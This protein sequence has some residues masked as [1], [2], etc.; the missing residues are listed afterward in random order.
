MNPRQALFTIVILSLA[1]C[2]EL[3]PGPLARVEFA[4]Y[5]VSQRNSNHEITSIIFHHT[6]M[7]SQGFADSLKQVIHVVIYDA[8]SIPSIL[9]TL[10]KLGWI[11]INESPDLKA[12]P[13]SIGSL[14]ILKFLSIGHTSVS[15]LPQ[16]FRD[17][18]KLKTVYIGQSP[19][20][21]FESLTVLPSLQYLSLQGTTD[22]PDMLPS[23]PGVIVL[24]VHG[25]H[26]LPGIGRLT[27]LETLE[28]SG[29]SASTLPDDVGILTKLKT[30]RITYHQTALTIGDGIVPCVGLENLF[31]SNNASITLPSR[32]G[33]LK[34]LKTLYVYDSDLETIP[35]SI[36]GLSSLEVLTIGG[37]KVKELPS[38]IGQLS[39]LKTMSIVYSSL[40]G[41][42]NEI[43]QLTGLEILALNH[44]SIAVLPSTIGNLTKLGSLDLTKN[45]ITEIPPSIGEL[46]LLRGLGLGDN[47]LTSLPTAEMKHLTH[48]AYL[49][50]GKNQIPKA[51]VDELKAALPLL[52]IM[53]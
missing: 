2:Q 22:I 28:I 45:E 32:L 23:L 19:A 47:Q 7:L 44:N 41:V 17:A 37:T 48:L 46:V 8:D 14:P 33:D 10:P 6:P 29:S 25:T 16:T 43:D 49:T 21:L 20:S 27:N 4:N 38:S 24:G 36:G 42:P 15:E 51:Q 31:I 18:K 30:I 12:I 13:A 35:E 9:G 5:E 40:E 34:S 53:D 52:K 26:E 11:F 39:T 3:D 50:L 1:G